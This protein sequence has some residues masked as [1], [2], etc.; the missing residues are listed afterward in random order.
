MVAILEKGE[1]NTDF[2]PMVDFIAASPLRIV[3]L[4]DTMLIHQGEGSGT[5]SEA[6]HTPFP[7]AETS[8]PSTSSILLPFIPTVPIPPVTQP[9]S[10]PIIQYSRRERIAQSSTLPTIADEPASPVRDVSEWEAFPTESGFIA[11]QDMAT[12][13]KSSTLPHDLTTRVT[14]PDADEG[15]MQHNISELTALCTSLQRQYSEL[16]AKFQAQEEE[17]VKLKDRVKVLEE[18]EVLAGGI[19]VPTGN[20]VIPTAGPPAI[21]ISTGNEVGPTASLI[22]TRRKGKEV[23]VESDTPKKMKL[24]E[25]IDAQVA[26]ELEEQQEKKSMRM[27]E[28]IARDAEVARIHAEEELQGMIDSLDKSNETTT[29]YLQEYQEF[30]LELSLEKRIELISDL[31]KY[32]EHYTKVYKFQ[33]QQRRPMTKKQKREYYMAVEDFIPMGSKEETER[34]NRKGLNLEKE[35]VKKQN[36]SEEAPEIETSTEEFTEEKI[37]EMMQLVLV[38]DVY[39]QALQVKHPIIDWKVYTEEWKLYDL[40]GVQH[41]TAKNKEIFM[42]VE[43]DYPLR[44]GLALVMISYKLKVENYSQM[45]E[46]LIRKIYNITNTLRQQG[47]DCWEKMHKAFPLPGYVFPLAVQVPTASEGID[48]MGLFPSSRGNKY[49]LVA[50]DY[51][52]KWVEVKA[53]L[54]NDARLLCKFFKNLFARFGTP[55]AIISDRGTHFCNDQFANVMLKFGVTYRLATPYHPQTSGQVKVSNHGLKRILERTVGKNRA[56]WS[57]KLDDALWTF[58]TVYNTPIGYT[59]YKL[60]YGKEKT[61]RLHDSKIKDRVFNIGDRVLLFNSRLKIFS[62]KLKSRW[63]GPFTISHVFPYGTVELSQPDRPNFK[64]NGHGLKYY[65]GKDVPKMVVPDL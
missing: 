2:H 25:Q 33:S 47:E 61:K 7:E 3:P 21:V 38:E 41:L 35:Q 27:N 50:V 30:A 24:Q 31:V 40:S 20:G 17:I 42:L 51:L 39:V 46:D 34:L 1:F 12:I 37:K 36:S 18:R 15:N 54:T 11:N 32:Q 48:F 13:V 14:S 8:H 53:L 65:F 10:T 44:K 64:V 52:S 57:D 55:R 58:Q 59:P 5:P 63:P 19:D 62:G 56:S 28:Q 6:H 26:R 4:F 29:K 60:V 9:V 43:K 45:A 22:V 49:I 23:M 16:Q